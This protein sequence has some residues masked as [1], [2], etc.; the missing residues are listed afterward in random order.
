MSDHTGRVAHR[1]A[2]ESRRRRSALRLVVAAASAAALLAGG[3]I[4]HQWRT[5][6]TRSGSRTSPTRSGSQPW[7]AGYVDVTAQPA[8]R[9]ASPATGAGRDVLLSFIV[10]APGGPC[11]PSWGS[12]VTLDDASARLDLDRKIATLQRH[13]GAI[14]VSFGGQVNHELG[15]TCADVDKLAAAYANVIDR[16]HVS[17]IDLDVEGANL[18]DRAA[19]QRRAKAV[20]KLQLDRKA[21][22]KALVI[23]LTLPVSPDGLTQDGEATV[24]EMLRAGVDLA[25]VNAMTMD[26]GN[27]RAPG[28]SML[29]A[30]ASALTA[31]Q[32]E[33]KILYRQAGSELSNATVWSKIGA[34]PMIGQNDIPDEVFGLDAAKGLNEFVLS[35]GVGR[36]SM[37]S[38][39]RDI[40]CGPNHVDVKRV[41]DACSGV[42]QGDRKFADVLAAGM[43][44][45]L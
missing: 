22:G 20:K 44:G 39:N 40:P 34:T 42:S 5:S 29:E 1:T 18:G 9:F 10:S 11:T 37:W 21:S 43:E 19:G 15:T 24:G 7:F 38:L 30:T 6:P 32:R 3:V 26:Y 36:V 2:E 4:G 12:A 31:T 23:W 45:R 25:G 33:L 8:I 14:A 13:G 16:Y 27:S 17:T 41:S 28:Q 35:H